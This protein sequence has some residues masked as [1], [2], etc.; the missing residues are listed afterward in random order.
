M[1]K[2]L[3]SN[4]SPGDF[5]Q[6]PLSWPS[7]MAPKVCQRLWGQ[8]KTSLSVS[9][10]RG[11]LTAAPPASHRLLCTVTLPKKVIPH[12][13]DLVMDYFY[14]VVGKK[15]NI[16]I[17]FATKKNGYENPEMKKWKMFKMNRGIPNWFRS[18]PWSGNV[19]MRVRCLCMLCRGWGRAQVFST[20]ILSSAVT[21]ASIRSGF[22]EQFRQ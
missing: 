6:L 9:E 8:Y 19:G 13:T 3:L 12:Q 4:L 15:D 20:V 21:M 1:N 10:H 17:V 7:T 14:T 11:L 22:V 18:L 5:G 2:K 16:F